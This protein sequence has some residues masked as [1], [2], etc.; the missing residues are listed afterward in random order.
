MK[1]LMLILLLSTTVNAGDA[2]MPEEF[3]GTPGF[4]EVYALFAEQMTALNFRKFYTMT[5]DGFFTLEKLEDIQ[6]S[7][8]ESHT[9]KIEIDALDMGEYTILQRQELKRR[10]EQLENNINFCNGLNKPLSKEN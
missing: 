3:V 10:R 7:C 1:K 8:A 4:T 5:R 2:E 9:K 6:K